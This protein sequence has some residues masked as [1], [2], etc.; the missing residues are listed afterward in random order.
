MIELATPERDNETVPVWPGVRRSG[1]TANRSSYPRL[2]VGHYAAKVAVGD[3]A[4]N[5]NLSLHRF[6]RDEA[7]P[8]GRRDPTESPALSWGDHSRT[9]ISG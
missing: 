1:P 6:E 4:L 8:G 3:V 7:R 2:N 5:N 9:W